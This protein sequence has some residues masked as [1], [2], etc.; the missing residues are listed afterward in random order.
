MP[1]SA[2]AVS[3][4]G[5]FIKAVSLDKDGSLISVVV[6]EEEPAG[7]VTAVVMAAAV[8]GGAEM[9]K[10]YYARRVD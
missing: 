8:R 2:S 3:A 10:A 4:R 9:R 5:H 7:P 6:L 1:I